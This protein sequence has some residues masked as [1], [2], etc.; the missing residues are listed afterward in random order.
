[1]GK[2]GCISLPRNA[3]QVLSEFLTLYGNLPLSFARNITSP[4]LKVHCAMIS[5][6]VSK[7]G[8]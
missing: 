1:M 5:R 8:I 7:T 6:A 3:K 4:E 2:W